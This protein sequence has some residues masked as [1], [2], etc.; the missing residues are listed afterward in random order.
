MSDF[1]TAAYSGKGPRTENRLNLLWNSM[2]SWQ[3]HI[4]RQL[5]CGLQAAC[6]YS[7][8]YIQKTDIAGKVK[9]QTSL[10]YKMND[11]I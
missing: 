1:R 8:I 4:L 2:T 11:I 7:I 3:R 10:K 5:M 9:I 6:N